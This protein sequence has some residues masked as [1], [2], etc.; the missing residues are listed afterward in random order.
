MIRFLSKAAASF[1]MT[2]PVAEQVFKAL[3]QELRSPGIWTSERLASIEQQL[4]EVMQRAKEQDARVEQSFQDARDK[5]QA[6]GEVDDLLHR[7]VPV[8]LSRRLVPVLH[9]V[10]RA[11]AQS[12]PVIWERA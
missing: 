12:E 10:R 9:I 3:G 11:R 4:E 8:G 2:D 5:A 7:E 1:V 6:T